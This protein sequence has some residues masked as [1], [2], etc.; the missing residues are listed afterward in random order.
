MKSIP[1][2]H[3]RIASVAVSTPGNN[4]SVLQREFHNFQN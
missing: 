1:A 3:A 2:F 4:Y